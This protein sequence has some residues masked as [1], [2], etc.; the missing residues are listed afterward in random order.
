M[1]EDEE[2]EKKKKKKNA[3]KYNYSFGDEYPGIYLT[4]LSKSCNT[5][6][7]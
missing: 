2:N 6:V 1:G 3:S 5:T 7:F 4:L